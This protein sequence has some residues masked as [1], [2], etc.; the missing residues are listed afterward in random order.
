M[1]DIDADVIDEPEHDEWDRQAGEQ[2]R[3]Y[4]AFRLYRDLAPHAR[5][6]EGMTAVAQATGLTERRCR[7]I[8]QRWR[9][10]ERCEAWDDAC[11]RIE[12]RQ[13]LDAIR[14]MHELHRTAGRKAIIVA[15]TAL[16][17]LDQGGR[18]QEMNVTQI[19][20][21]MALG[22]KLERDTLLTSVEE[23]QGI[24]EAD[25]EDDPW[26]RIAREL[27]DSDE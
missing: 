23:L 13:R 25:A 27:A 8:A 22:A 12:D 18:R 4:S 7:Q 24:D 21:L 6:H 2:T 11:H 10:R 9:W 3:Y 17:S 1:T 19:A 5:T 26:E 16:D 15:M 20:R 14:E